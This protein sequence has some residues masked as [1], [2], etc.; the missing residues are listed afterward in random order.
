MTVEIAICLGILAS[1][2]V[3]FAWD[4]IPA[5]VVALMVMLATIF[6]GI[7][8]TNTA[9]A[10]FGSDTVMLIL[11]LLIMTAGLVHTG[12]VET[13]G[14][15]IF[16]LAG[17]N[18]TLFL[19]TITVAI[20]GI[21]AFMS[22]TAA[23]AFFVPLVM[24]YAARVGVSPSL[25]LLPIAFASILASSVTLM[26]TSTNIVVSE[27]LVKYDQPAIGVFELTPV[28]ISILMVGIAYLLIVGVRLIPQRSDQ[29]PPETI[30]DRSYQAELVVVED[31]P[32]VG[33]AVAESRLGES[34]GIRIVKLLRGELTY[35]GKRALDDTEFQAGDELIVVG[36]RGDLVRL[37]NLTG[38][39]FK[40]DVH[41]ADA[42]DASTAA[43]ARGT[44]GQEAEDKEK[45]KEDEEELEVV[46]GVL[47]PLSPLI[48]QT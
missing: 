6:T 38:V 45:E 34:S 1:A 26:A 20:G 21:S 40:A 19:P 22:N 39:T 12:I 5:E 32:L 29:K 16:S 28:G 18:E 31:S 47:M 37:R 44:A 24:G 13:V 8:P 30:G 7:L 15:W 10:G 17:K 23:T 46:E 25:Y 48:G 14:R 3:L 11:G 9:F 35:A 2:L 42:D 33:K 43:V 36:N 4:R 27:L 41:P